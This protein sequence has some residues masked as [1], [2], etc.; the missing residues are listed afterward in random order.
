MAA[1]LTL[2]APPDTPDL[3]TFEDITQK[4]G[5]SFVHSF[6]DGKLDNIVEGTGSG[7]MFLDYDG[8]GLLDI[9]V[10]NGRYHPEVSDPDTGR[11]LRGKLSNKLYR[12]NG[13]G[14]FT[15]VTEKAGVGGGECYSVAC[16]AADYDGDGN[17]DILVLGYDSRILYHN[18]GDGTFTE[19]TEKAGLKDSRWGVSGVWFDYNGDGLLDLYVAHYLTYDKGKFR[20]V[21]P[22][23][24]YPGPLSYNGTCG[25][26]YRNNGN[27]TFTE[28]TR[29]AGFYKPGCRAMS[30]TAADF[31]NCGRLDVFVA[32]DAMANCYFRNDGKGKFVEE[33]LERGV[34]YGENGQGV[35]SM[36]PAVG[37]LDRDGR[38]DLY[39]PNLGYGTLFMNRG[40]LFLDRTHPSGIGRIAGQYAGWGP[41]LFDYDNDGYLDIFVATGGAHRLEPEESVLAR[42][43]GKGGFIDVSRRSGEYFHKK[44]V[45]RGAAYGDFMNDGHVGLLVMTLDGPPHLLR[46]LGGDKNHWL[47]VV[48]KL[49][50]GK[51][52]AIG[53]RVTVTTTVDAKPFVQIHDVIPVVGYLSQSDPRPHFGLGK[54]TKADSVEIRWPDGSTTKL[55]D[56]AA[57]QFLKVVQ[58]KRK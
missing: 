54:A 39:I 44:F 13:D 55:T 11:K 12:N 45:A 50:N 37:D 9:Y 31:R 17:I 24:V 26:L 18:N 19:V 53:A 28:V 57:D 15:D 49:A 23:A 46:N 43:N 48:P 32:N 30:A 41:C 56:V 14:T 33:G 34:A 5:I 10:L 38:L 2:A 27:G 52:D 20:T 40:N 35:A 7:C 1:L 51:S 36:G 6:G 4:A 16:S 25:A 42:N 21:Y 22:G 8:D 47:T 29:E 3:P 58:E